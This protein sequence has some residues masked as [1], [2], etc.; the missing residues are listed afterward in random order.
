MVARL[1]RLK[2]ELKMA[3]LLILSLDQKEALQLSISCFKIWSELFTDTIT[4][5]VKSS[6]AKSVDAKSDAG[7]S[8]PVESLV[9]S[10]NF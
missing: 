2:V 5:P 7:Y 9:L 8:N 6:D 10:Q 4:D 1:R 3:V